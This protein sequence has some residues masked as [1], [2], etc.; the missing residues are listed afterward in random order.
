MKFESKLSKD[1]VEDETEE[2]LEDSENDFF[3]QSARAAQ[4]RCQRSLKLILS[5]FLENQHRH[6]I[7]K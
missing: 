4:H 3:Q 2:E 6:H 5:Q 1:S 7:C